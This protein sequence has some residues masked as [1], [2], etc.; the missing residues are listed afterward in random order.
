MY[1]QLGEGLVVDSETII[2]ILNDQMPADEKASE[3]VGEKIRT[4]GASVKSVILTD[5]GRYPS[6]FTAETVRKKVEIASLA[7]NSD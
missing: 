4:N 5:T 2:A 6:S 7:L 1:I 3:S